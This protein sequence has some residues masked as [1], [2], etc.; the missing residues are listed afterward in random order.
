MKKFSFRHPTNKV[1]IG[2][3]VL[4]IAMQT[5]LL[6][7][8][9]SKIQLLDNVINGVGS[10]QQR[11][12]TSLGAF[13]LKVYIQEANKDLYSNS[14]VVDPI[15]QRVYFPELKIYLPLTQTA[16][17]L[18]YNYYSG[19]ASSSLPPQAQFNTNTNIGR[20]V[21]QFSDAPCQQRLVTVSVNSKTD[22]GERLSGFTKLKDGRTLYF[23]ENS[24]SSCNNFWVDNTPASIVNNLK[25][26][27]SY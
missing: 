3:L 10:P 12:Q 7:F 16:R 27:Q 11:M 9:G 17:N 6:W 24:N 26:A 4:I 15:N 25:Q 5:A 20:L 18:R 8:Y 2:I 1:L 23:Y 13:P 19:D 21:N 14:G 22:I